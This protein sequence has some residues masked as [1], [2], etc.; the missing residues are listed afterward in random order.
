MKRAAPQK[1][2]E[3]LAKVLA[4]VG[5]DVSVFGKMCGMHRQQVQR[6]Q[7]GV[8]QWTSGPA[9]R[10]AA[11][12]LGLNSDEFSDLLAGSDPEPLLERMRQAVKRGQQVLK[13]KDELEETVDDAIGD[14]ESKSH[15]TVLTGLDTLVVNALMRLDKPKRSPEAIRRAIA[16]GHSEMVKAMRSVE[17]VVED[18]PPP[19]KPASGT[20][21]KRS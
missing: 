5:L 11:S 12:V 8:N 1:P 6:I 4:K 18:E 15:E 19:P 3:N 2:N 21:R 10:N 13:E 9:V 20:S 16:V 7:K 17:A 14:F